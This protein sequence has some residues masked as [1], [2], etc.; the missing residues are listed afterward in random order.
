MD[1]VSSSKTEWPWSA[2]L[3]F[4]G[5]PVRSELWAE[6]WDLVCGKAIICNLCPW[7]FSLKCKNFKLGPQVCIMP[8]WSFESWIRLSHFFNSTV[9]WSHLL[10]ANKHV[11]SLHFVIFKT[12]SVSLSSCLNEMFVSVFFFF[13]SSIS[14][15]QDEIWA[16]LFVNMPL[17]QPQNEA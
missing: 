6:L 14:C 17:L 5:P 1:E 16:W 12:F 4:Y 13:C 3:H 2:Y 9:F 15:K 11:E 10:E 8:Y 7:T